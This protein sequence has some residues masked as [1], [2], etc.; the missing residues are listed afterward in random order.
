MHELLPPGPEPGPKGMIWHQ[1]KVRP[2][3][4]PLTAP[5]RVD[6]NG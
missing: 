4:V 3:P 5:W 2:V 6:Q 1:R